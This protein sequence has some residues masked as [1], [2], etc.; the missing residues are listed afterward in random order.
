MDVNDKDQKEKRRYLQ[1]RVKY[2]TEVWVNG[3][4]VN[5]QHGTASINTSLCVS[6]YFELLPFPIST[7][8][9]VDGPSHPLKSLGISSTDP[10]CVPPFHLQLEEQ[11]PS[12]S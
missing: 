3:G 7:C 4:M 8:H 11:H 9:F 10:L 6:P 5:G 2:W 12:D 1:P